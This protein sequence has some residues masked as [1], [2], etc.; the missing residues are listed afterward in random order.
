MK[1]QR[2]FPGIILIGFGAYF[3]LAANWNNDFST[4]LYLADT[5]YHCWNCFFRSRLSSKRVMNQFFRGHYDWIWTSFSSC[6]QG[7]LLAK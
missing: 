5:A 3:L 2:I 4:I 6:R 7:I 1:N